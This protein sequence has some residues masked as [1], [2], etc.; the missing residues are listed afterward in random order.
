MNK[1]TFY[2]RPVRTTL[3]AIIICLLSGIG[4]QAQSIT[5][6]GNDTFEVPLGVTSVDVEAWGGGGAGGG[7]GAS[8]SN[9]GGGGGGG[10]FT[11]AVG[12][13]VPPGGTVGVTVGAGGSGFRAADGGNG[14]NSSFGSVVAYG[15][16]GGSSLGEGGTGGSGT[17]PGGWGSTICCSKSGGGGGGAGNAAPGGYAYIDTPGAGG[18]AHG[19]TGGAGRT[20]NGDGGNALGLAGG[21]GGSR[22]SGTFANQY[23]G[24]A[25]FRGQVIV[26]Y[27][28]PSYTLSSTTATTSVCGASAVTVI[29]HSQVMTTG[30]YQ[31][32]YS[33]A[34][35]LTSTQTAT[36]AFT[37][38]NPGTGTFSTP[39]L[40]VGTSTVTILSVTSK[41]CTTN[42]SENN[43]VTVTVTPLPTVVAGPP[44]TICETQSPNIG[45]GASATNHDSLLWTSSGT[46]TFA[47]ATSLAATYTPSAA[48]IASGNVLLTLTAF[49]SAPCSNITASKLLTISGSPTAVAGGNQMACPNQPIVVT[50]TAAANGIIWWEEDGFGSFT[51]G[52]NTTTPTYTPAAQD[53]GRVVTLR[54]NVLNYICPDASVTCTITVRANPTAFA[55][56][57]V[58]MC[59]NDGAVNITNGATAAQYESVMWTSNG[60]GTI[61]NAN[62]LTSAT[63]TAAP[64]ERGSVTLTLTVT[65]I[66]SCSTAVATKTLEVRPAPITTNVT[67]FTGQTGSVGATGCVATEPVQANNRYPSAAVSLNSGTGW[68]SPMSAI[69]DDNS[70]ATTTVTATGSGTTMLDSQTLYVSGYNFTIPADA[71]ISGISVR[72][73]RHQSGGLANAWDSSVRLVKAGAPIGVNLGSNA[74]WPATKTYKVY[75]S[76]NDRWGTTWTPADV[77]NSQFGV[78]LSVTQYAQLFT[79]GTAHVDAIDIS[80]KY[81]I[82]GSLN[83]YTA[84]SGGTLL[85][86]GQTFNPVGVSGSALANTY[87]PGTTTFYAECA[88]LPGCRTAVD[89]TVVAPC[90]STTVPY[91]QNFESAIA[92]LLPECTMGEAGGTRKWA[93]DSAP[94]NGFNSKTLVYTAVT[95][96]PADAWFYTQGIALTAGNQYNIQYRYGNNSSNITAEKLKVAFGLYPGAAEMANILANHTFIG[97]GAPTVNNV[98]FTAPSTGTYY[99]GFHAYS[100][101]NQGKLFVDDILVTTSGFPVITSI[102]ASS[103]CPGDPIEIHG[104]NLAPAI[105]TNIR[106]GGTPVSAMLSNNGN[107]IVVTA[108]SGSGAVTVATNSGTA[109]G[110]DYTVVQRPVITVQPASPAPICA[111][112]G[113]ATI[114]VV[115]TG[116]PAYQ[117]TRNDIPI[118]DNA[119][120]SGTS[121]ATLT[122][123]N[124]P[125]SENGAVYRALLTSGPGCARLS[126][127]ATLSVIAPQSVNAG[128][129]S[130]VC[131]NAAIHLVATPGVLPEFTMNS[132]SQVPF[133]DIRNS[134]TH[135]LQLPLADDSEHNIPIPAFTFNGITYTNAR[136]GMN[137]LIALGSASGDLSHENTP[138]PNTVNSA[139]NVYLAPFWDDLD[140]QSS[141]TIRTNTVGSVFIIQYTNAGHDYLASASTSITFQVQLH[142]VTGA[143]TF[144]YQDV[145]FGSFNWDYGRNA[146]IGI[147]TS[148]T[149]AI[150]Y[151][152]MT[153]SLANGQ[154]ITFTPNTFSYAWSGPNAFTS[155]LQN[156]MIDNASAAAGGSYSVVIT[157]NTTGCSSQAGTTEVVVTP[158][159]TYYLDADGDTFGNPAVTAIS[160]EGPL[161]GYVLN[162]T[163]CDDSNPLIHQSFAFYTDADGDSYGSGAAVQICAINAHTAPPGY[164]LNNTDCDDG[165]PLIHQ[166]FAFYT[167]ADGD[168]YGSGAAVQI[169]AIN[170][171]TPPPGYSVNNTD[172]HDTVSA[173]HPGAAEIPYNG[174]DDD[175]DGNTDETGTVT[176]TLL[177]TSCGTTLAS[178]GSLVGIAT[179]PNHPITGYRIRITHGDEVQLIE[180][181]APHF[182]MTQ[183]ASY[184]YATTY[185]VEI[186]LQRGGI[187]QVSWGAPCLVSTPAILESGAAGAVNP[188]QCGITLTQI[189]TLIATTSLPNVT[190]YRFRVTNLSDPLGPNAVQI[191]DRLQNWFS[192]QMLTRYN[193]GS[194]YRIEVSVKTTGGY[195]GYGAPCEMSSPPVPALTQC[196]GVIQ[197]LTTAVATTSLP[198]ATQYRFQIVRNYDGAAAMIDRN[199]NW[200][201]FNMVPA[202]AFTAGAEYTVRTAVMTSGTWSPFGDACLISAP[203]GTAKS[204]ATGNLS[205]DIQIDAYPMPFATDF[206]IFIESPGKANIQLKVYDMLGKLVET[207]EMPWQ[208]LEGFKLGGR[209]PSGVYNLVAIQGDAVRTIRIIKR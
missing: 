173:I 133:I 16:L 82:P 197:H 194:L 166:S 64:G 174:V 30:N 200:F 90:Q 98:V 207:H 3:V 47:N 155:N 129:D 147:Q 102:S 122:I 14:G 187:W 121:T 163:D 48:D 141:P 72:V 116:Q 13:S 41:S 87:T 80:I 9:F 32:T 23:V 6:T 39:V 111:N 74:N 157:N 100:S 7:T 54:M 153:A 49:A 206:N 196:E 43:S 60:S 156:P 19:G 199:T 150:M 18:V 105:A 27:V 127:P 101:A 88:A 151:S 209:Y 108:N 24:G 184:T 33:T 158:Q 193:Y 132:N 181:T 198:G 10:G 159:A 15:G 142:L 76:E 99:F 120:F 136:V 144:V 35:A 137:G 161:L 45:A 62:S 140:I 112:S 20:S 170:A 57:P 44:M 201:N 73:A 103:G 182:T 169:C 26:S 65:G 66:G 188:S 61:S 93:T 40:P 130:P 50:G 94:G 89:F 86:T 4:I 81:L 204:I 42:Q 104:V 125:E 135:V 152:H 63:Y 109:T 186:Q 128:S 162:N 145:V 208:D 17:F 107:T 29:I 8:G 38:G 183:L 165:N 119:M 83:W 143:I 21:G 126:N 92:T 192:L 85:G 75:G 179:V 68:A 115:A 28:C 69:A 51:A 1:T 55:G 52:A 34:G 148:A 176:T 180:R 113:V 25:G 22:S 134:G 114:S 146:T 185:T 84:S 71:V 106:I 58:S 77:N 78:A 160:C 195:G 91:V 131:E 190:G 70:A 124:V 59:A 177:A 56:S 97:S 202:T 178:I 203:G 172:C 110:P 67:V 149:S 189:N 12:V 53:A 31:V 46:G 96:S 139:G 171:N 154:S 79:S 167:D 168:S 123:S 117:W 118:T 5:F 2:A 175:C 205:K 191:L 11:K 164:S 138:M 37:Q 95:S 36:V